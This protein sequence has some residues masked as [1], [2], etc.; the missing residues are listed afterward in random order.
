MAWL[1]VLATIAAAQRSA[2]YWYRSSQIVA[3]PDWEEVGREQP[4]DPLQFQLG[5]MKALMKASGETAILNRWGAI[6][7]AGAVGLGAAAT[8]LNTF[9]G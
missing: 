7:T 2:W 8:L 6:W 3:V 4:T 5:W 1:L 9:S